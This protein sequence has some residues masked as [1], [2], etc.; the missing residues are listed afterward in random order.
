M[1]TIINDPV[2]SLPVL[3][4]KGIKEDYTQDVSANLGL[5][6]ECNCFNNTFTPVPALLHVIPPDDGNEIYQVIFLWITGSLS[7]IWACFN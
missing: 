6:L 1:K 3:R 7:S 4:C 5:Y 2:S